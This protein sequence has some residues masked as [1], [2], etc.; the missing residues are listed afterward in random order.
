MEWLPGSGRTTAPPGQGEMN[1][2]EG[3]STRITMQRE[4]VDVKWDGHDLSKFS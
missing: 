3:E 4:S 2:G 1:C